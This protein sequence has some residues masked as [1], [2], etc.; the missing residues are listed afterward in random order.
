MFWANM[1]TGVSGH[2]AQ[3]VAVRAVILFSREITVERTKVA[4]FVRR[5]GGV[6]REMAGRRAN[7]RDKSRWHFVRSM[8]ASKG[9]KSLAWI[10]R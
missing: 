9:Q 7:A 6:L 5:R 2:A 1:A 8:L 3:R 4:P 10:S